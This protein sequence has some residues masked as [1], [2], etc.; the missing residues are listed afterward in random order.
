MTFRLDSDFPFLYG[1]IDKIEDH[2]TDESAVNALIEKF[3]QENSE[4]KGNKNKAV[5][6][7]VSNCNSESL[8]EDYVNE[9]MKHIQVTTFISLKGTFICSLFLFHSILLVDNK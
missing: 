6:W 7:F 3:G 4:L 5:A 1:H 9:L 2:S 8:R